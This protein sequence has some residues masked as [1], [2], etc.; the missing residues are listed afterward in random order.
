[1]PAV[2][3]WLDHSA[4]EQQRA[5]EIIRF[6]SQP[7]SRDELGLGG[8]RD[9]LSD[10]LFPGTSV[11]LTRARYLFFIPWLY[12]E[13]ARRGHVGSKLTQWVE[14]NER[15]LIGALR[16][17]GD[18]DG[19]IGVQAGA[20]IKILPST[21]YWNTLRRFKILRREATPGEVVGLPQVTRS[22]D[23]ATEFLGQSNAVW[24]PTIPPAPDGFFDLERCDF[25]LTHDEATW[26][27]ERIVDAVPETLLQFLVERG[28][29]GSAGAAY[30][31]ED[32][33]AVAATGRIRDALNEARRFALAMHGAALLYNV[34]LAERA[35]TLGLSGHDGRRDAFAKR[36]DEWRGEVE[37]SDIGDWDLNGLWALLAERDRPVKS[38]TREFVTAWVNLAKQM[39]GHDLAGDEDAKELVRS[40]ELY[41]KR[42]QARL[43]NDRLMRQ[44]GGASGSWRLTF[45]WR[46][47]ARLLNDIAKGRET[48]RARP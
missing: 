21:I 48:D 45:R 5:R 37:K 15:Q 31:W 34:L 10:S 19:L 43:R 29:R 23:D 14:W 3:A 47:V 41:Q 4:A 18:L 42:S 13:G 24:A 32:P 25:A 11:L 36:L 44:W 28:S 6:F 33:D 8:I 35:E 46:V 27:A 26:L 30:P 2:L 40:R 39:N 16:K 1:M 17:G 22:V 7:E 38:R 20:A 12:R 9:A